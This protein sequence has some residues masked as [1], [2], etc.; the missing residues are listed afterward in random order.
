[1]SPAKF[2]GIVIEATN[3]M[4]KKSS[5]NVKQFD[6]P[7]VGFKFFTKLSE[8]M[9][10]LCMVIL[11]LAVLD[12]QVLKFTFQTRAPF[13]RAGCDSHFMSRHNNRT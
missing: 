13:A 3:G 8:V 2:E 1:M 4:E 6:V 10:K 5:A 7:L 11:K 12:L 9:L